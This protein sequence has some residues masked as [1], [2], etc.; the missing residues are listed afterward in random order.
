MRL[1]SRRHQKVEDVYSYEIPEVVRNRVLFTIR[2]SL[3]HYTS[4]I[5]LHSVLGK[6]E[7]VI[8]RACGGLRRRERFVPK[9]EEMLEHLYACSAEEFMDFLQIAFST[10]H[11]CGGQPVLQ[12]VNQVLE[13]ENVGYELTPFR[14]VPT[15]P[16]TYRIVL[17]EAVKKDEKTLHKEAV[18]PCLQVLGDS[19]FASPL[20]EL[21]KAFEEYKKR[22]YGDAITDAG[23]AF[24]S[25]LKTICTIKGWPYDA[26]K[27]TC[28]A[29]LEHCREHGLFHP[30]YRSV[31]E[32]VATIRNKVGDAHGK[33]PNP[34]FVATKELA[35][36]MLY[37]VCTNINLVVTLAQL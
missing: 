36:H 17:P 16:D 33:G 19:R 26:N 15:G 21:M 28:S 29:L 14:N 31:L 35:D 11:F 13:E 25:V 5:N 1:F 37:T 4:Q 7:A 3:N 6:A 9:G 30:F 22:E 34:E 20:S 27:D 10:N 32:G 8:L 2:D 23:A 24:E 18:K 12:L